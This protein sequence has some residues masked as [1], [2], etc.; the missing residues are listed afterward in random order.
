MKVDVLAVMKEAAQELRARGPREVSTFAK[1]LLLAH[2]AV[3]EL[4]EADI[5]YTA[6]LQAF[7][8]TRADSDSP[9]TQA[10][11]DRW[12]AAID[13]RHNALFKVRP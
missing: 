9:A 7:S 1:E 8:A 13:R 12:N 3:A 6:S 11:L 5:E 4:I 2:N 10:A